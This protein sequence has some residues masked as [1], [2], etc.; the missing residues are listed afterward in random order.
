MWCGIHP[1]QEPGAQ[2]SKGGI[3]GLHLVTMANG[4]LLMNS[5][6]IVFVSVSHPTLWLD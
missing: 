2:G 6:N 1:L 3:H 5:S 4:Y